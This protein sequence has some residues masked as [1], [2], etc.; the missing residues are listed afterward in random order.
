MSKKELKA[1]F[2]WFLGQIEKRIVELENEVKRMPNFSTWKADL[3]STSLGVLGAWLMSN[4]ETRSRT[5]DEIA[6]IR[7]RLSFPIE[8]PIQ[9]LTDK[10]FSIAFDCGIYFAEVLKCQHPYLKWGQL[11][12]S[13]TFSDYGQP[14]LIGTGAVPL[15]PIR[16]LITLAYGMA[17]KKQDEKR[18][19][20]LYDIWSKQLAT[21]SHP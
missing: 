1:Y 9:E 20:S 16:I 7:A 5:A 8:I 12:N 21:S 6:E 19:L 11:L 3:S 18:L 14:L 13:K 10:T 2:D 15:N 17:G 4:V